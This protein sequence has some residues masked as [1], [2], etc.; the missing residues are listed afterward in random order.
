MTA[1]FVDSRICPHDRQPIA[2][3]IKACQEVDVILLCGASAIADRQDELPQAVV[4]A[5][6]KI[7]RF[8][9]P[10]DPGN[11]LMLAHLGTGS[12]ATP[13]IGMPGRAR[14]PKLNGLD[15]VLQLV[16]ADIDVTTAECADMAAGGLLMEIASRPMPR[17]LATRHLSGD[18]VVGILLAAGQSRRMGAVNKLLAPLAGKPLVRHATEAMLAAGLDDVIVVVGYEAGCCRSGA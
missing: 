10:V 17:A 14:S 1:S 6:G 3:A 2:A 11:L 12:T 5:G 9:L 13:V 16:L 18:H 8:G 15:W 4:L 7:D